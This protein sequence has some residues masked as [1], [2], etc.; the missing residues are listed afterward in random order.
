MD[1]EQYKKWV[2]SRLN[3]DNCRIGNETF[4]MKDTRV[5]L[6]AGLGLATEA[7]EVGDLMKKY[8]YHGKPLGEIE[9]K[10][11]DEMGDALWYFAL[12]CDEMGWSLEDVIEANVNKLI[13]R[14]AEK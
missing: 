12:M 10:T 7:G 11:L 5:L 3:L 1:F 2:R 9:P 4:D 6:L 13:K 14:S 8:V